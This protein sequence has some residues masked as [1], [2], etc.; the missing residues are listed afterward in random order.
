M[1]QVTHIDRGINK[2][3]RLNEF[4]HQLEE[5]RGTYSHYQKVIGDARSLL[6]K[7]QKTQE[8]EIARLCKTSEKLRGYGATRTQQRVTVEKR[9]AIL[10]ASK[11]CSLKT[12]AVSPSL[13]RCIS[14]VDAWCFRSTT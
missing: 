14:R 11:P 8:R 7:A 1:L 2:V 10:E 3:L 4:T 9:I 13:S 6:E 5:Y 12:V